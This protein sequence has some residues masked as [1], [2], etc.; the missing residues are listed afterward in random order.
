MYKFIALIIGVCMAWVAHAQQV[1]IKGNAQSYAG[2]VLHWQSHDDLLSRQTQTLASCKVADNGDF[3]FTFNTK[4]TLYTFIDLDVFK[5]FLYV[6][7]NKTYE[8]ILPKKTKKLPEDELNPFF[9]ASEYYARLINPS[10]NGLNFRIKQFDKFYNLYLNKYLGK[11]NKLRPQMVDSIISNIETRIETGGNA[12]FA[13]YKTYSYAYLQFMEYRQS[14]DSL[15]KKYFVNKPVLYNNVAY[16]NLFKKLFNNYLSN[17]AKSKNGA[18]IP[19]Y[20]IRYRSLSGIKRVMKNI[21]QIKNDTLQE[22]VICQSLYDNF[23]TKGFPH[24]SIIAVIDSVKSSSVNAE[25]RK[26]AYNFYDKIT[27]LLVGY[28]A[29]DFEL[30]SQYKHKT[31]LRKFRGN[32]VYLNFINPKSYACLKQLEVLK[33]LNAKKYDKLKIVSICI[34]DNFKEMKQFVRNNKY[35]WTFLY[36]NK[37]IL[38]KYNV[39]VYPTYYMINPEGKLSMSPAFEPTADSFEK[40]YF[41]MLRAWQKAERKPV[42]R[43]H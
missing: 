17:L 2:D 30:L 25:N 13:N 5:I 42:Q 31:S 1:T 21:S 6:E 15:I 27:R 12:F 28:D 7:P 20:L 41:D 18:K 34:C 24:K 29:T 43:S 19:L 4:K 40:R 37:E 32:F 9:K 33:M 3:T 11:N 38:N 14:R 35:R 26:I 8:I 16:I 10:K 39:K 22:L 36:G 23:Y